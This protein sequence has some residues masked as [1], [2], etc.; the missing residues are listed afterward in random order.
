LPT[1][2]Q[3]NL[4][5]LSTQINGCWI[6]RA[7]AREQIESYLEKAA[8][9]YPQLKNS[10]FNH[11]DNLELLNH[12]VEIAVP[13]IGS[14]E[15]QRILQQHGLQ[16]SL[17][18]PYL[19]H[20]I[21]A[22]SASHLSFLRPNQGK[23]SI[24]TT[25]HY[26]RSLTSYSS[27]IRTCLDANN[28]DSILGCCHLH[29]MLAFR[30]VQS[31]ENVEDDYALT[32]LRTMR[33]VRILRDTS[34]LRPCLDGCIWR[35]VLI[36]STS[37]EEVACNHTESE[38]TN[39]WASITS[40]ALHRLCEVEFNPTMQ[41]NP[42]QQPLSRLCLLMRCDIGQDKIGMF[43][44]FIGK[45][46]YSFIQLLDQNDPRAMLILCYWC[47]LLSQIEQWWIVRSANVECTRLCTYLDTIPDQRIHDMLRFPASKCG[48]LIRDWV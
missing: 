16:L 23:Y 37:S 35:P 40:K 5:E 34:N 7:S 3:E 21:L 27:Q 10:T 33:G 46:P 47:A 8:I 14:P 31:I 2:S 30:N 39:S 24:A 9:P 26:S 42:Y 43:M 28:A 29:T 19:L 11:W 17:G 45:L 36:E 48:Y 44:V 18:A 20:A 22:F 41:G 32:W 25:L 4:G 13:C 12:F 15:C 1:S 6:S 38:E